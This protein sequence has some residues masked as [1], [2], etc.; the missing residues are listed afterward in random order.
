LDAQLKG[1]R[2][3]GHRRIARRAY[4]AK[5][6]RG[7]PKKKREAWP[8]KDTRPGNAKNAGHKVSNERRVG[9]VT[10]LNRERGEN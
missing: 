9:S 2:E 7:R 1:V 3:Q 6:P 8:Q 10:F 5:K 4:H